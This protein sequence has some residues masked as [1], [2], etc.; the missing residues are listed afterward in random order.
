MAP[1]KI[2]AVRGSDTKK[3]K[4]WKFLDFIRMK[5]ALDREYPVWVDTKRNKLP[6]VTYTTDVGTM[7][8]VTIDNKL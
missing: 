3:P 4:R 5:I 2:I 1:K 6:E 8:I 7:D